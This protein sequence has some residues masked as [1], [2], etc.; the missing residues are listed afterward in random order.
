MFVKIRMAKIEG[1]RGT[2]GG[3]R[4]GFTLRK[5]L[6]KKGFEIREPDK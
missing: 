5:P 1:W 4:S 6:K 2:G 3:G